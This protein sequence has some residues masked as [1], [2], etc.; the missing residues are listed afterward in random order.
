MAELA[1]DMTMREIYKFAGFSASFEMYCQVEQRW[2]EVFEQILNDYAGRASW[3]LLRPLEESDAAKQLRLLFEIGGGQI[4]V[5]CE[6]AIEQKRVAVTQLDPL[7]E[8]AN[9]AEWLGAPY[10]ER[11][12]IFL[13][14]VDPVGTP[15]EEDFYWAL[16]ICLELTERTEMQAKE[17]ISSYVVDKADKDKMGVRAQQVRER[18]REMIQGWL[19]EYARSKS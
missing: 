8:Q 4:D 5:V 1:R 19:V 3:A 10:E 18:E 7:G 16:K 11:P 15:G 13:A 9:D 12:A 17:L 2:S 14:Y 6:S